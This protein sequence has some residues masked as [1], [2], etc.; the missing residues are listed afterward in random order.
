MQQTV[1]AVQNKATHSKVL[2]ID[3]CMQTSMDE[4]AAQTFF[5]LTQTACPSAI[6]SVVLGCFPYMST[7]EHTKQ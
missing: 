5:F 3:S 1:Q 4:P 7:P 6:Y 2:V